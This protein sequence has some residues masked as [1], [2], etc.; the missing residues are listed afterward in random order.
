MD[1]LMFDTERVYQRNW[2][3]LLRS[4]GYKPHPDFPI[5]VAG[6]S[7]EHMFQVI[8]AFYPDVDAPALWDACKTAV[9][10]QLSVSVPEKP[11]LR[12]IL[13]GLREAGIK[14]AVASSS[15]VSTIEHNLA[16]AG[17]RECFDAVVSSVTAKRGKPFPD[18]FL[19]AARE[20]G[21]PP[22]ACYVLEDSPNGIRSGH[23][24]GCTTIMVPDTIQP[25]A[26]LLPLCGAVCG[27]LEEAWEMIKAGRI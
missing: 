22:E 21:L 7:G 25:D 23:A 11:G 14:T 16:L 15:P 24:A 17:V 18:V 20:L 1:G 13:S 3:A 26:D 10:Q 4:M 27:D 6:T 8:H 12:V 19:L 2:V 5:Q 9:A